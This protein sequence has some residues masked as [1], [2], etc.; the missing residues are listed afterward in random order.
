MMVEDEYR[1]GHILTLYLLE[2]LPSYERS[3]KT[4]REYYPELINNIDI[5]YEKTRWVTFWRNQTV[6]GR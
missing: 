6:S 2:N 5:S 1:L 4:L 3:N